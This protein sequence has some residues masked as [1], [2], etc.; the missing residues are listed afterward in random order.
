VAGLAARGVEL[1]VVGQSLRA[2]CA[3]ED[4]QVLDAARPMLARNRIEIV[5]WFLTL[6]SASRAA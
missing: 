5:R 2:R 1:Y 3:P 4:A 6:Q